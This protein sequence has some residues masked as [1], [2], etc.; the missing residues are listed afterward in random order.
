[1]EVL[2][3]NP[4]KCRSSEEAIFPEAKASQFLYSHLLLQGATAAHRHCW[5]GQ[6]TAMESLTPA[7][8]ASIFLV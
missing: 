7:Q 2:L 3:N 1:M 4:A 6:K 5:V 8:M